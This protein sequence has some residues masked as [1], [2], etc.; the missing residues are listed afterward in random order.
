MM[1]L[2]DEEQA[3]LAK[4]ATFSVGR[5]WIALKKSVIPVR[6]QQYYITKR[7]EGRFKASVKMGSKKLGYC[8]STGPVGNSRVE[9]MTSLVTDPPTILSQIKSTFVW[10]R[11]LDIKAGFF[12]HQTGP[13]KHPPFLLLLRQK[14]KR[15]KKPT[16][17]V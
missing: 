2:T 17:M 1:V 14:Q 9:P 3:L 15:K 13:R 4:S 11:V 5:K 7:A 16:G 12:H 8:K 10:Y 6:L